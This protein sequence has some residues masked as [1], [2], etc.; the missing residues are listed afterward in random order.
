MADLVLEVVVGFGGDLDEDVVVEGFDGGGDADDVL[1]VLVPA[2]VEVA[3]VIGDDDGK[4]GG[5][6]GGEDVLRERRLARS[7]H[8]A[9]YEDGFNCAPTLL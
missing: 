9:V 7:W 3:G 5:R 8:G 1:E 2:V 6:G 4:P